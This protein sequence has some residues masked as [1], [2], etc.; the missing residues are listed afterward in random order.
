MPSHGHVLDNMR[1]SRHLCCM[2][3]VEF[4]FTLLVQL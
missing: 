1:E 4:I 3:D 2:L